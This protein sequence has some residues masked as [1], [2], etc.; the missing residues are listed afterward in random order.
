M[1]TYTDTLPDLAVPEGVDDDMLERV[2]LW[3]E[4]AAGRHTLLDYAT[5]DEVVETYGEAGL[6][7]LGSAIYRHRRAF[8]AP[9]FQPSVAWAKARAAELVAVGDHDGAVQVM[10]E[11]RSEAA[12]YHGRILLRCGWCGK[13][14]HG[15][16]WRRRSEPVPKAWITISGATC[17]DCE[18]SRDGVDEEAIDAGSL[19]AWL[20]TG[21]TEADAPDELVRLPR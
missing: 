10:R 14:R 12:R 6:M 17:P 2:L 20:D 8:C 19:Y 7:L 3:V 9:D 5:I 16:E 1:S 15:R 18:Q 4:F 13:Y 21:T 11:H